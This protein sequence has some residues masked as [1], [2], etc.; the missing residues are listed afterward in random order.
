[1]MV[2]ANCW[3]PLRFKATAEDPEAR[4][5]LLDRFLNGSTKEER[6]NAFMLLAQADGPPGDDLVRAGAR[7]EYGEEMRVL[8]VIAAG[9]RAPDHFE[10]IMVEL[11]D[12]SYGTS[13][14]C[15]AYLRL[16]PFAS[17]KAIDHLVSNIERASTPDEADR[18]W[19]ALLGERSGLTEGPQGAFLVPYEG[20]ALWQNFKLQHEPDP[21]VV[22]RL[23]SLTESEEGRRRPLKAFAIAAAIPGVEG[24]RIM[25]ELYEGADVKTRVEMVSRLGMQWAPDRFAECL[26]RAPDLE[27]VEVRKV[28]AERAGFWPVGESAPDLKAWRALEQDP[29][30][31]DL[32]DLALSRLDP[33]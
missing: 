18:M 31:R 12:P 14:N 4:E 7:G 8:A 29:E 19:D 2:E 1:M 10:G 27:D 33:Q 16:F 15:E 26:E 6:A 30:T 24:K 32:I 23:A 5:L 28:I 21:A 25:W 13:V 22:R 17:M 9:R 11:L 3:D 20:V